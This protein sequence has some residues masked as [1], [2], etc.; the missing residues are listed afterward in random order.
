MQTPFPRAEDSI[1]K[2]SEID[3]VFF[4]A[5]LFSCYVVPPTTGYVLFEGRQVHRKTAGASP[6]HKSRGGG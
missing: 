6:L 1:G 2:H 5:F 4:L 3:E